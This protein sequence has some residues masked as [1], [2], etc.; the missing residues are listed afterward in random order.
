[1][2]GVAQLLSSCALYL[3]LGCS[4]FCFTRMHTYFHR[5]LASL[6]NHK[7][8]SHK[9][10]HALHNGFQ[11]CARCERDGYE[12]PKPFESIMAAANEMD[13]HFRR[14]TCSAPHD[15]RRLVG[16]V[17]IFTVDDRTD[18]RAMHRQGWMAS[19]YQFP[20]SPNGLMTRFVARSSGS[21]ARLPQLSR[22]SD[23]HG[24]VV[25]L[26]DDASLPRSLGPLA[27]LAGW[28][29]CAV[30]AWPGA[31][32]I[33][34]ADDDT[35]IRLRSVAAHL[36]SAHAILSQRHHAPRIYWG[37]MEAF[38]WLTEPS[39]PVSEKAL[40]PRPSASASASALVLSP[41]SQPSPSPSPFTIRSA[42]RSAMVAIGESG[43]C[44]CA[45]TRTYTDTCT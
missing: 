20:H 8:Y 9:K 13:P 15:Y 44:A 26:R 39:R 7:P 3:A 33:G 5:R 21:R 17:G 25:F 41:R 30:H 36:G 37:L 4:F 14:A 40:A 27:S 35:L 1:M 29:E 38:S 42:G 6:E 10:G 43:A 28:W 31:L 34:K 32:F 12:E 45:C 18:L 22:E 23:A 2:G 16:V 24:D 11:K 19:A